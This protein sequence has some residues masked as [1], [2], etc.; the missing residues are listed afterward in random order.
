MSRKP[1]CTSEQ[2]DQLKAAR[3]RELSRRSSIGPTDSAQLANGRPSMN[4]P[5]TADR[6]PTNRATTVQWLSQQTL[7]FGN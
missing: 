2:F 7:P 3:R 1:F 5:T 6:L 4:A